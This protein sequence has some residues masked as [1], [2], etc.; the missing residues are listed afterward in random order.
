MCDQL[1]F[2]YLIYNK[3]KILC[4]HWQHDCTQ[5]RVRIKFLI[6]EVQT[7]EGDGSSNRL[8]ANHHLQL[9]LVQTLF[10]KNCGS[11]QI[12]HCIPLS[13]SGQ[14]HFAYIISIGMFVLFMH[15]DDIIRTIRRRGYTIGQ[16]KI[17]TNKKYNQPG[18][19]IC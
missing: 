1:Y 6:Q 5:L 17:Q 13:Y 4:L 15:I 18:P 7:I 9:V 10:R 14:L 12:K 3:K 8:E 19:E 11:V 16:Q 2:V